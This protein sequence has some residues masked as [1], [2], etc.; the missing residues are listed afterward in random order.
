VI[1]EG[2][3]NPSSIYCGEKTVTY[4][5]APEK[6]PT[7]KVNPSVKYV[8]AS[9][10]VDSIPVTDLKTIHSSCKLYKNCYILQLATRRR[11]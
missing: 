5:Y 2:S 9:I 10:Y 8:F 3:S 6:H 11:R 7:K 4:R 1:S